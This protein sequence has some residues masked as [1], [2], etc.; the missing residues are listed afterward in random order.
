MKN[1]QKNKECR[2]YA[3]IILRIEKFAN[4]ES[5]INQIANIYNDFDVEFQRDRVKFSNVINLNTFL[6][7]INDCKK[8]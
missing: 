4:F 2:K 6:R 3:A 8:N 7:N 5:I 1:V